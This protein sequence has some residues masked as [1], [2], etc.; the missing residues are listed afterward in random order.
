MLSVV[1]VSLLCTGCPED[2]GKTETNTY[3]IEANEGSV[4]QVGSPSTQDTD[5][6]STD[7]TGEGA[8]SGM[9][10][11]DDDKPSQAE[12]EQAEAFQRA[13]NEIK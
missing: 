10:Q 11:V 1:G 5:A 2:K 9:V 3:N 8:Q 4:V 7:N 12:I 13:A 6:T